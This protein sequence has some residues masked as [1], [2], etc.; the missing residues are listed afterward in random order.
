MTEDRRDAI[1]RKVQALLNKAESTTFG[2]EQEAL[3]QKADRLMIDY[4][5]AQHEIDSMLKPGER[6]KPEKRKV[7]VCS[8]NNHLYYELC[9]LCMN[10]CEFFDCKSVYT[11][12]HAKGRLP[13]N[14]T[15]VGFPE[16]VRAAEQLF[17]SL[18]L[19]LMTVIHPKWSSVKSLD[20]N[21]V[22]MKDSGQTWSYIYKEL[23]LAEQP[24]AAGPE[25]RNK[26]GRIKRIYDRRK[27]DLGEQ[28]VKANPKNFQTNFSNGF[29]AEVGGRMTEIK[30]LR[31]QASQE[32]T[33]SDGTS[34]ALVLRSREEEVT[35]AFKVFFPSV[36]RG[37]SKTSGKFDMA[38]Q[39]AGRAAGSSADLSGAAR[40]VG[41]T[42]G[43]LS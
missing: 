16:S 22:F 36:G 3:L 14:A 41:G 21:I 6:V 1:M 37:V 11:G 23:Q 19:Q 30:H 2:P 35:E 33:T 9:Q 39:S 10:V 8:A 26:L 28:P 20:D 27:S 13:I 29:I 40:N 12:L 17:I 7:D 38:A 18:K 4:A 5:I 32:E 24:I 42:K 15:I 43:A 31:E 34:V 25:E